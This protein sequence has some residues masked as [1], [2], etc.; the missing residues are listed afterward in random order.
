MKE[1]SLCCKKILNLDG[2]ITQLLR[3]LAPFAG[4]QSQAVVVVVGMGEGAHLCL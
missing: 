3:T 1:I 4:T 2:E